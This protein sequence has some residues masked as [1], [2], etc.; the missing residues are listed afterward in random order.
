M[1]FEERRLQSFRRWPHT[2]PTF[3]ATPVK[4]AKSGFF[5]H[6]T[7]QYP[8]RVVCFCCGVALVHWNRHHDPWYVMSRVSI[9]RSIDELIPKHTQDRAL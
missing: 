8:D 7:M 2:D 4:L 1:N 6:P 5:H 9:D 3:Q